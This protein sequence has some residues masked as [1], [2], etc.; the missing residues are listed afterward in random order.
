[1]KNNKEPEFDEDE[2]SEVIDADTFANQII[3]EVKMT[4][5]IQD[6]HSF[7]ERNKEPKREESNSRDTR[8]RN[9]SQSRSPPSCSRSGT[10]SRSPPRHRT[11][12]HRSRSRTPEPVNRTQKIEKDKKYSE[13][14]SDSDF[15][16]DSE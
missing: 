5:K 6:R 16:S 3:E 1:M 10:R 12:S 11:R 7:E 9:I 15:S 13:Y 14:A 8:R 4:Q 2:I